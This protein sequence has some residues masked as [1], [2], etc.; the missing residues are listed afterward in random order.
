MVLHAIRFGIRY[1]DDFARL[2]CKKEK[3]DISRLSLLMDGKG[4]KL[5]KEFPLDKT[6]TTFDCAILKSSSGNKYIIS[7][8]NEHG[9]LLQRF[10][11]DFG[12]IKISKASNYLTQVVHKDGEAITFATKSSNISSV[13]KHHR[14]QRF[15]WDTN[16]IQES[17]KETDVILYKN[18]LGAKQGIK[19]TYQKDIPASFSFSNPKDINETTTIEGLL[20]KK[21][22]LYKRRS[23][24]DTKNGEIVNW[25]GYSR[26]MNPSDA[27]WLDY[28]KW[29]HCRV[30]S[31]P[32]Q[33][34]QS[35]LHQKKIYN[36]EMNFIDSPS[37]KHGC[38]F[39]KN[40]SPTIEIN[41]GLKPLQAFKTAIHE[42]NHLQDDKK[43]IEYLSQ[44]LK[45][46]TE[47]EI[48]EYVNSHDDELAYIYKKYLNGFYGDKNTI[49]RIAYEQ[50]YKT[51]PTEVNQLINANKT[52]VSASEDYNK[53][54]RNFLEKRSL[55][56]ETKAV[57][58]KDFYTDDYR[59]IFTPDLVDSDYTTFL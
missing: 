17:Y 34:S 27:K 2:V 25:N 36:F 1:A 15:K 40:G 42:G 31:N 6:A 45:G 7:L 9:K 54:K 18:E 32:Q 53:Y 33:I 47:K 43:I 12:D 37:H 5:P 51:N 52:Y 56:E 24:F 38:Y 59:R 50:N 10:S 14:V 28:D 46:K 41:Q 8:K 11:T 13:P 58:Q 55:A 16:G 49:R 35:A 22:L 19:T 57:A 26:G 39:I 21:G 48:V 3:V 20:D 4:I 30:Q 29:L 23:T 44:K